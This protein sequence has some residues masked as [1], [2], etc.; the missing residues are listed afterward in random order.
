MS[1]S[2]LP[3]VFSTSDTLKFWVTLLIFTSRPNFLVYYCHFFVIFSS[4]ELRS[5]FMHS[6]YVLIFLL[7]LDLVSC[8]PL[9]LK[10]SVAVTQKFSVLWK[11]KMHRTKATG[12]HNELKP[13]KNELK[14]NNCQLTLYLSHFYFNKSKLMFG[15]TLRKLFCYSF[16]CGIVKLICEL[17]HI[18]L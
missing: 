13:T 6:K 1:F 10:R 7:V 2:K 16:F 14:M 5:F 8:F 17:Q 4:T 3:F 18:F 12:W 9:C 11:E 15:R